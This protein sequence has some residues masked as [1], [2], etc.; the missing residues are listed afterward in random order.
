MNR[1]LTVL[2]YAVMAME[3]VAG[4]APPPDLIAQIHFLGGDKISAAANS[5]A[6][7]NFFCSAEARVLESQTLDKLSRAPG[8]WFKAKIAAGAT[9]GAAQLRPLLDDLLKSEWFFEI[10]DATNGS[11]EYALAIRLGNQRA[12]LWRE[13]LAGV[14]Q[15]WTHLPARKTSNGWWLKKDLPPN[16]I[17]FERHGDRV[18]IDCGQDELW[19]G[20]EMPEPF[21][22]PGM[23]AAETNW[24][25]ADLDWPRLAR[26][27]PPLKEFD[28][29]K[30][31][32]QFIGR[33]GDLRS[34]GK[35]TLA[36]PLSPLEKWRMPANVIRPPLAS[37]TAVR[38]IGSW[39]D[40]QGW[41]RRYEIQPRPDQFFIW[42]LPQIP[43]QT[44][45]AAPVPDAAAALTQ[46]H[47]KLSASLVNN[48]QN[49][50]FTTI[51]EEMTNNRISWRGVPFIAPFVQALHE[52]GGDFLFGGIFPNAPFS[53]PLPAELLQQLNTPNLVYYHWEITAERLKELPELTRLM[54]LL[55]QHDQFDTQSAAGKWLNHVGPTLGPSVTEVTQTG[56]NELSFLRKSR[57]GLTAI[58]LIALANWL[59]MT[60][61]PDCG[62]HLPS[63]VGN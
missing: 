59:E 22:K 57:G 48:S 34:N 7:T 13:N 56:P 14:L 6:V 10:R 24:L 26:W 41:A 55:T 12:Q 25:T 43:F 42:A 2:F 46:L 36:Q 9:D 40:R 31:E 54:L 62:F 20:N 47:A 21:L 49:L 1:F 58:E 16:L 8:A 39:L 63:P 38:G 50:F 29:P 23:A 32:L 3:M 18:V 33:D 5:A 45:A 37:F 35:F 4:A 28:F 30:M 53:R 19:L 60:N 15:S 51:K 61:F 44:F 52:P 27:F 11:P 17:R